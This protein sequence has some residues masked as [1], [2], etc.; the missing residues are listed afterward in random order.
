MHSRR[1]D[2]VEVLSTCTNLVVNGHIRV[3]LATAILLLV[4]VAMDEEFLA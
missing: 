2:V 1:L 4:L 3:L